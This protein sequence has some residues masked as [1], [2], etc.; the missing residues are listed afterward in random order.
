MRCAPLLLVGCSLALALVTAK[1]QVL[2]QWVDKQ[3]H[4]HIS[5]QPPPPSAGEKV[6]KKVFSGNGRGSATLPY[7]LSKAMKDAPVTLYSS[8]TCKKP[9]AA[10][11]ALLN[12]RGVPF[13]EVVVWNPQTNAALKR[14]SG[15]DEV[16]VLEVG[17]QVQKGFSAAAFNEAL[18]IGGYPKAGLLPPRSQAAP[19]APR[20]YV[21]PAQRVRQPAH[22][23]Q[24]SERPPQHPL[25]PY[26][27]R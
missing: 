12:K 2:Y 27:P 8:P 3:G 11:R 15:S 23:P 6:E 9:C 13:R 4:T 20:G 10:A 22:A 21:P 25:G 7:E 24:P 5:D 18:D 26:A 19:V 14:V 16:P 17:S 1:A